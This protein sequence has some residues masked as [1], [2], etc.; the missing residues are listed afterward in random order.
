MEDTRNAKEFTANNGNTM[1]VAGLSDERQPVKGMVLNSLRLV[2]VCPTYKDL[3]IVC[4]II[5]F[6]AGSIGYW[7]GIWKGC[8]S[9]R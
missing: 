5:W 8:N 1:L 3:L 7:V 2:A 4:C 9:R 6:V